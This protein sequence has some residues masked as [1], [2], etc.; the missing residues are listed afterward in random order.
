MRWNGLLIQVALVALTCTATLSAASGFGSVVAIGGHASDIALDEARGVVYVAN[1]TANRIDIVSIADNTIHTSINV[2]PQPGSIA[3]SPDAQFL[4]VAHFGN[5]TPPVPSKNLLTLIN[6]SSHAQQ[7]FITGDPP[8]GVAF[9]ATS[10]AGAPAAPTGPGLA[11]VVTTTSFFLLD[12]LTGVMQVVGTFANL[13]GTLPVQPGTFPGQ[14][15]DTV[16]TTSGDGQTVWGVAG[17]GTGNQI[18]YQYSARNNTLSA[19]FDTSS[20]PLLPRVS[21]SNDGTFAMIGWVMLSSKI[22]VLSKFPNVVTSTNVTGHVIDSKNGLI[23]AQIPDATQ[24]TAPPYTSSNPSAGSTPSA[25]LPTLLIM[26]NDNLTVRDRIII[27]ENMVGRAVLNAAASVMYAVS[28]SGLMVLPVGSLNKYHR[29]NPTQEDLLIQTSFCNRGAISGTFTITDPGGGNTDFTVVPGQAGVAV[30]P[31]SGT[32]P[33]T[34]QVVIDPGRFQTKGTTAVTLQ[35]KSA[36]AVNVPRSVRLLVSNPD[37][38]Q[39]GSVLDVPGVLSDIW[40]DPARSRF[41]V[42]RQDLNQLLFFDATTNKQ[43]TALRTATTPTMMSQTIDGKYLLVGHDNSQLVTVY[44]LDAMQQ[45]APVVL[46]G[47]HYARSIAASNN[48]LLVLARNEGNDTGV[49][50][51]VDLQLRVAAPLSTL[52]IWNNDVSTTGVLTASPNG[53]NIL[54][55]APD[56]TVMVYSADAA[57]F[58]V[59]RKD[60]T[61]LQG[62]FAASSYNSYVVGNTVFDASLVPLGT[63]DASVGNTFGFSFVGQGGY[64]VT[65]TAASAAG[66]IQN[67]PVLMTGSASPIAMVEAPVLPTLTSS[68][69]RTVA[70]IPTTNSVIALTTSGVTVLAAGYAAAVTPPQITSVQSAG[71]SSSSVAPGGL[72]NVFGSSMSPVNIATQQ[73][74]LPTALNQSCLTVNGT[75][76]PLLYISSTQVNAQLPFNVA[77]AAT[78][79]IHTP[80]GISNNFNFTIQSTAPSIFM[81]GTA[82]PETGLATVVRLDDWQLVTPTNPVHP[83]DTLVIYLTGMGTTNPVVDAGLAAPMDVLSLTTA[84]PTVTLGGKPLYLL[85]AGLTPGSVSGI[86]QINVTV[87]GG[88]PQG[89]SIPLTIDQGGGG[90]TTLNVRV[91]K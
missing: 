81:T 29:V 53:A 45:V 78:M 38:N 56:G 11:L 15:L 54:Y 24:P 43:I 6:L 12:P 68:F 4:L 30:T 72:I 91:V 47:G 31:S 23:Y 79:A 49:I 14:I 17:A 70:P 44:D 3:I 64:R 62:A 13:A 42:L 57:T 2:P 80:G 46:P 48:A 5:T 8:L 40:P 58:T 16:L 63:L 76:I 41:Y 84:Q 20:P 88:V 82:G 61:A 33:A 67:L 85:Y 9:V 32:T 35:I 50:D 66:V 37:A 19:G 25:G 87:P 27:P 22:V 55:A 73:I 90:S 86:Y 83:G 26:D 51:T 75:P 69:T 28:D 21:V 34:V 59:A 36:T 74:P 39:R 7:S 1:F 52:G 10:P 89:M 71:G 65:G 18:I 60:L 77:G